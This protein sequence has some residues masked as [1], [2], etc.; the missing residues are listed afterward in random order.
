L[1]G[2]FEE[3]VTPAELDNLLAGKRFGS[4]AHDARNANEIACD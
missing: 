1:R 3:C 4:G 2:P